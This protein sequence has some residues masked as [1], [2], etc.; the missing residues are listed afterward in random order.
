MFLKNTMSLATAILL[1]IAFV[2]AT[3]SDGFA[4]KGKKRGKRYL[5]YVTAHSHY[6]NGTMTAPVRIKR[7]PNF[8]GKEVRLPGGVWIDCAVSCAETLRIQK[9]DFFDEFSNGDNERN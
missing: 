9:V 1:S 7:H 2:A 5:G 8:V 3:A 4:G 6:G